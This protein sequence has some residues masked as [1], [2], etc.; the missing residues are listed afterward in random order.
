LPTT[1]SPDNTKMTNWY[2]LAALPHYFYPQTAANS[3]TNFVS[4]G[5]ANGTSPR[6]FFKNNVIRRL[7][8]DAS[9]F[10]I[11]NFTLLAVVQ[12]T[13][14]TD[15]TTEYLLSYDETVSPPWIRFNSN[16]K[17]EISAGT[18]LSG[19]SS[20][21]TGWNIIMVTFAGASST[22]TTNGVA[23]SSGNIG[24]VGTGSGATPF[25]CSDGGNPFP[26][27]GG[28]LC[29][30]WVWTNSLT[31]GETTSALHQTEQDFGFPIVP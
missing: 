13:A 20:V 4:G 29:R 16:G 30:L 22:V 14:A 24:S 19:P 15:G 8:P 2:N 1:P 21:G 12:C 31:A 25:I 9:N 10:N 18:T 7:I 11:T 5:G 28:N 23:Y 6:M 3:G 26:P 27:F 17:L